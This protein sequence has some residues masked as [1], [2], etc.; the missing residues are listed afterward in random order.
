MSVDW[1][2]G[3]K[4]EVPADYTLQFRRLLEK[5][6]LESKLLLCA[7][8]STTAHVEMLK[9]TG[10]I[11]DEAAPALQA[12]AELTAGARL[13]RAVMLPS[14]NDVYDTI[15]RR[16]KDA[17]GE[18]V[19]LLR[20]AKSKND[21]TAT[22]IRLYLRAEVL[23]LAE[24]IL[25]LRKL[26]IDL[27]TRDMEVVMPGYTHMQPAEAILL[28]HWWLMIESRLDRDFDRLLELFSRINRL[29]LGACVMAG[30]KE[31]IDRDFVAARLGFDEVIRNSLDAV[32]DRDYQIEFGACASLIGLHLSQLGSELLLWATQEYAFITLPRHLL[33]HSNTMP[34]KRNPELLEVLRA[35]PSL[36]FG[37]LMEFIS[38]LKAVPTGFSQDLQE[39]I[40]GVCDVA[41][42]LRLLLELTAGILPGIEPDRIRMKEV[43]CADLVNVGNALDYLL[44]RGVEKDIAVRSL[45]HLTTYCRTRN[46]YLS[47]LSLSEW[48][49]FSPAFDMDIYENIS[50]EESI[51]AY[52]SFGCSSMEQV[53]FALNGAKDSVASDEEK[54]T[55]Q[56]AKVPKL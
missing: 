26:L 23:R 6:A 41:E 42:T 39:S 55:L 14:D 29:P 24:L 31:P 19:V 50:M 11:A 49:R 3:S 38:E 13:G 18:E 21:Q 36:I 17:L 2:T 20:K 22:D 45:E 15:E 52:C 28:S 33:V 16:L 27:S 40:P 51:G 1:N 48:Q 9:H 35:R 7:L 5:P 32:T 46:K 12:L 25:D 34:F 44:E 37:R 53:E 30:S 54:L 43:A 56:K 4:T 47:D 8:A 10:L